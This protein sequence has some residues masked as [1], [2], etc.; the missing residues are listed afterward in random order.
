MSKLVPSELVE[1]EEGLVLPG[2]QHVAEAALGEGHGRAAG[3]GVEDGHVLVELPD[4]GVG[5]LRVLVLGVGVAPGGEEV[6]APASGGLRVRGDDLDVGL[7]EVVPVLDA[8]RVALADEEHHGRGVGQALVRLPLAPVGGDLL[9]QLGDG[10]DVR[11]DAERHHVGVHP[12]DDR[13]RL[14]AGA[15]MGGAHRHGLPGLGLPVLGERGVDV[16]VEL[17]GRVVG[18]VEE[19][20]LGRHRGRRREAGGQR[21]P[22]QQGAAARL[23]LVSRAHVILRVASAR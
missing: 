11:G 1:H 4:E 20:G 17:A 9:G 3:A 18:D 21:K 5:L 14:G 6:P 7:G 8:L 15:A 2:R 22:R 23:G 19:R 13:A 12:V 10:V 16:A